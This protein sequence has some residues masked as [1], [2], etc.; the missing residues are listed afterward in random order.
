MRSRTPARWLAPLA[1]LFAAGAVWLT[2]NGTVGISADGEDKASK[3]TTERKSTGDSS[4][5]STNT[6]T[7]TAKKMP[8]TYSIKPGDTLAAI[9]DETGLTVEELQ[10][11]NPTLDPNSLTVD[12]SVKLR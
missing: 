10:E 3:T 6:T 8:K 1:L 5:T 11:V 4:L 12:Q 7:P 2:V 9:A